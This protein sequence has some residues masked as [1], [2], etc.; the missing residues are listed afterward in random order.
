MSGTESIPQV[1]LQENPSSEKEESM[2]WR[3]AIQ[4]YYD[5]LRR[6]GIKGPVISKNLW[7]I[8]SPVDLLE[9]VRDLEPSDPRT[10]RV[11][12]GSLRRFGAYITWAKR[13]RFS[14]SLG[15][16]DERQGCS[17]SLGID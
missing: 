7:S 5:E 2:I 4:R 8:K 12:L 11:W 15:S 17:D 10:S 14:H 6:G 3:A 9:Q 13:F 1:S 16:L